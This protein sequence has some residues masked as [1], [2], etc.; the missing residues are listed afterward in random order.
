MSDH[1]RLSPSSSKR[2]MNCPG[3]IRLEDGLTDETS[4][5]AAEGT[6]AHTLAEKCLRSGQEAAE[7]IGTEIEVPIEGKP[8]LFFPVTDEMAEAVQIYVDYV[9]ELA[10]GSDYLFIERKVDIGVAGTYGTVDAAVL[11]GTVLHVIDYKHGRG[12]PVEAFE[13]TQGLLYAMGAARVFQDRKIDSVVVTIVQPRCP[14]PNGPIR[15]WL[16]PFAEFIDWSFALMDAAT[17]ARKEGAP[18]KAGDWCKFCKAAPACPAL[19][20][21]AFEVAQAEFNTGGEIVVPDRVLQTQDEMA[22][23]MRGIPLLKAWLKRQEEYLHSEACKG[24]PPTGYKLVASRATR[25]WK[26]AEAAEEFLREYGLAEY[27]LY[28]QPSLA[29]VPQIEKIIGKKNIGDIAELIE[30][31]SSGT[32]LAV[33]SDPRPKASPDAADEFSNVEGGDL[34]G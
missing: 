15:D 5:F 3:S 21:A 13:N 28:G 8:S 20:D 10:V 1:A 7:F 33:E 29:S 27:E 25:K 12:V 9:Q 6:A 24:R 34:D 31:V 26:D 4:S 23:V 14:H 17:E 30:K 22:A 18:L 32:I 11:V 2:W 19:R 16:V